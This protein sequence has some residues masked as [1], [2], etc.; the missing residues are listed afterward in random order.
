MKSAAVF[1]L[2]LAAE[3]GGAFFFCLPIATPQCSVR[4]GPARA[5]EMVPGQ[6]EEQ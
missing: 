3:T 5:L 1:P 2:V 4:A 6:K